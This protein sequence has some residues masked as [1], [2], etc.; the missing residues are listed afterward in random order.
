MGSVDLPHCRL[1]T[2]FEEE[3]LVKL[4]VKES[5]INGRFKHSEMDKRV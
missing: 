4:S 5:I 3:Q 2:C 1:F